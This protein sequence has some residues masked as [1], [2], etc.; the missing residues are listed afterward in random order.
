MPKFKRA[1]AEAV[2]EGEKMSSFELVVPEKAKRNRKNPADARWTAN[3]QITEAITEDTVSQKGDDHTICI[4]TG[5]IVAGLQDDGA[6]LDRTVSMRARLNQDAYDD[7]NKQSKQR[8]AEPTRKACTGLRYPRV[9]HQLSRPPG[10]AAPLMTPSTPPQ[11]A[12]TPPPSAERCQL[13]QSAE[14]L[15][16]VEKSQIPQASQR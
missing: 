9:T 7:G 10:G 1:S 2:A 3:V 6:N 13:S 14:R 5:V 15:P 11:L 16:K 8:M 4:V 12:P